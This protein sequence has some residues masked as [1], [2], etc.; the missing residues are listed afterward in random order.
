MR[1]KITG[2]PVSSR[3]LLHTLVM[4]DTH[5]EKERPMT[6]DDLQL[7]SYEQLRDRDGAPDGSSWGLWGRDDVFGTLNL[8]NPQRIIDA[9][10][11]VR[12]GLTLSLNASLTAFEPPLFG[13]EPLKHDVKAFSDGRVRDETISDFNTQCSS[14][15][16][17][18]RHV[19]SS[20]HG[21]YNGQLES[22]LSVSDWSRR[23]I[24]GRGVLLDAE[25]WFAE[26]GRPIVQTEPF[27]IGV[28]DLAGMIG[29]LERPLCEGDILVLHTGWLDYRVANPDPSGGSFR[30]PGLEPSPDMLAFLW[31]TH[32]AAIVADN[33]SLEI[34]PPGANADK[35]TRA[36]ARA[37]KS[38]NAH[39]F[40]HYQLIGLLGMAV[41]ELWDTGP[42]ARECRRLGRSSFLLT[43]APMNLADGVASPANALAIL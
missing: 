33:P 37:S 27:A 7:P 11:E 8:L 31:D 3:V 9:A 1:A 35:A 23:G 15:W 12:E 6:T 32:C 17:G 39:I 38:D 30:S 14:Q 10:G 34:W 25:R 21:F 43:S 41:G 20:P 19:K 42:L 4:E 28:E 22:D 13:R 2:W 40:M 29:A 5:E 18:F 26:S 24:V 36:A 16:D